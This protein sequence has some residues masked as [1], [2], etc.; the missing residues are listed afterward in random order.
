[1]GKQ[2]RGLLTA[3]EE[4]GLA[5]LIDK[6]TPFENKIVERCDFFFYVTVIRLLDNLLLDKVIPE[7][8]VHPIRNL[9]ELAKAKDTKAIGELVAQTAAG[10]LD[11][12]FLN[13]TGEKMVFLH[14]YGLVEAKLYEM[15]LRLENNIKS[16]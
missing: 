8:W 11:I 2:S 1:M 6:L 15:L 13:E 4:R 7:G 12:P 3:K 10:N 5:R 14:A 9:I 16:E